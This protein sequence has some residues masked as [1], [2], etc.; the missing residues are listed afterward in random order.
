MTKDEISILK[1]GPTFCPTTS[2]TYLESKSE[3]TDFTRKL[4]IKEMFWSENPTPYVNDC[5]VKERSNAPIKCKNQELNKIIENIEKIPPTK[6]KPEF[7]TSKNES[8]ALNN[9][10]SY[11]DIIIKK[12]DK[13][14]M[15]IV[16]DKEFYRDKMVLSDHLK[17][18]TYEIVPQKEDKKVMK[19]LNALIEKHKKCLHPQEISYINN[20]KWKSSNIYVTPKIH[21]NNTIKTACNNTNDDYI[22]I[23]VPPD[24]K[25]RPIIAGPEAPTQR[26]SELLEKLL[27]PLVKF[28]DSFIQDDWDF[29]KNLPREIDFDCELYSVDV[30]SLYTSIPHTLGIEAIEYYIDKYRDHIPP[31][32]TKQF[33]IESTLFVLNNNN[34]FFDDTLWHQK[35]GTAMGTK[36]APPYACLSV[37]FLEETKLYPQLSTH[38]NASI[39]E[40]IIR[41]LLRYIDDGFLLWLKGLDFNIFLKLLNSLNEYIQ[42]TYEASLKYI[43]ENGDH[44]Q[45]LS[46][47]D[48][49]V[50]LRNYR[51]FSTDIFYKTT[52]S[53]FY[54]DYNSHHPQHIKNNIPYNLAKKIIVF[55]SDEQRLD[56]RLQQLK[57]WL[58]K[59]NYPCKLID[60][61]FHDAKLQGPAP[62]PINKT[63]NK[64]I[65]VSQFS[66]NLSHENTITQIDDALQNTKSTRVN[67]VF[68]GCSTMIAYKQ[69]PNILRHLTRASFTSSPSTSHTPL[70]PQLKPNGL[71]RCN[72]PNCK[73]CQLYIQECNSFTTANGKNWEIRSHITCRSRNVLYYLKCLWCPEPTVFEETYS[74][75]TNILRSRM[76]V[77]ISGCRSGKTTDIFDKHVFQCMKKH[78]AATEPYF[79]IYAFFTVK[80]TS[81]LETY[82]THLHR[83]GLDTMNAPKQ[84]M[85]NM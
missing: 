37:G 25:G 77:H 70:Q 11:N 17:T 2:C 74:G 19:N 4:K 20:T 24:L 6:K 85:L 13:G 56:F 81:A 63:K 69:P 15:L 39:C 23:P 62:A 32:F 49:L 54:L 44:I 67:K 60:K 59:C 10:K 64:L 29:H 1:K 16:M 8:R 52:N 12:A 30:V 68:E 53:H 36:M 46:F 41:W 73:L 65:F 75:R 76:N 57:S 38:F 58:L 40:L 55:V 82:E 18:S 84:D 42:F 9:L 71:F 27:S 14:S 43:D 26:L 61:G 35:E 7:N 80:N 5:L 83:L 28:L 47:L 79:H 31:R 34:F 51:Y 21:K 66:S 45:V 78:P 22:H 33:I 72:R 48:L 3:I 50:I